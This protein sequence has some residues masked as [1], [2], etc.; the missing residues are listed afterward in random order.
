MA[1]EA[2]LAK[3]RDPQW[4]KMRLQVL[5]RDH[6]ACQSCFDTK[7]TLNVHHL[8]YA[9]GRDPWDYPVEALVTL[10]EFCHQTETEALPASAAYLIHVLKTMGA[11]ASRFDELADAFPPSFLPVG[12]PINWSVLV[13]MISEVTRHMREDSTVWQEMREAYLNHTEDRPEEK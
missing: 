1:S 2:Y 8:W 5:E 7:S 9:A 13:F 11:T 3:L 10:C 12:N 6:W 4:Q